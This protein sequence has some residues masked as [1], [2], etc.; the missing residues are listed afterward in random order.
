V[1]DVPDALLYPGA[2]AELLGPHQTVDQV[3]ADAG[4]IAYEILTQLGHRYHRTIL[5]AAT[6]RH[7]RS[8]KA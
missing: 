3:A 4:T 2:P 7:Q 5:G 6:I 8:M 1:T